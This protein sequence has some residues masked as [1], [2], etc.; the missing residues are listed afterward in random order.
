MRRLIADPAMISTLHSKLA[1]HLDS[2]M[3]AAEYCH[4]PTI[5]YLFVG[6]KGRNRSLILNGIVV[7]YPDSIVPL[8][9][10]GSEREAYLAVTARVA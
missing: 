1:S 7:K 3:L 8:E 6:R 2:Y 10:K 4:K 9:A 5:M